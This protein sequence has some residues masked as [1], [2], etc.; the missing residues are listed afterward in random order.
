M[1]NQDLICDLV[2][3]ASNAEEGEGHQVDR[4]V[5]GHRHRVPAIA[6]TNT[7]FMYF[8][9]RGTGGALI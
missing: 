3:V 1:Q 5:G 7:L 8:G 4:D 9:L 2:T 6:Q